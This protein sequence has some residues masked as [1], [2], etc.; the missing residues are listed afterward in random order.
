MCLLGSSLKCLHTHFSPEK[1][2]G[3]KTVAHN[4]VWCLNIL[5]QYL[6]MLISFNC[7]LQYKYTNLICIKVFFLLMI[8]CSSGWENNGRLVFFFSSLE[9]KNTLTLFEVF[10]PPLITYSSRRAL[11]NLLIVLCQYRKDAVIS[12]LKNLFT[13]QEA[14]PVHNGGYVETYPQAQPGWE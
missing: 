6:N 14:G 2:K 8:T 3:K 10:A 12:T 11:Y 1:N 9:K 7:K 5:F 13:S 4:S